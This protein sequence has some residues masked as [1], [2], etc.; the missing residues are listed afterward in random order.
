MSVIPCEQNEELRQRIEDY[1]ETLKIEACPPSAP[2]RHGGVFA[3][4]GFLD[5]RSR[6]ERR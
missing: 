6:K 3:E 2:L 5:H 1:A 4:G